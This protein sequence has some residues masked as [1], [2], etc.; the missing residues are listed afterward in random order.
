[1]ELDSLSFK[2]RRY[3]LPSWRAWRGASKEWNYK[4]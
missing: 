3:Y 1:M 4:N 2:M